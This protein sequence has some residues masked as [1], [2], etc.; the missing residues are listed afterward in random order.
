[1][2]TGCGTILNMS[3]LIKEL[4]AYEKMRGG[5]ETEHVGEWVLIHDQKLVAL[6]Q[7]FEAAAEDAVRRF[8]SGPYLIRQV[9]APPITLSASVM[10]RPADG[11]N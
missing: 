6:Y 10:Y 5:L 11:S 1:M 3:N 4:E 9:G 2:K 7:S 8:G